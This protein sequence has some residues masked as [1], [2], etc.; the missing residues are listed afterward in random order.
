MSVKGEKK[1]LKKNKVLI[2]TKFLPVPCGQTFDSP[3]PLSR[4]F[5][6]ERYK[7]NTETVLVCLFGFSYGEI[8]VYYGN[9]IVYVSVI[10]IEKMIYFR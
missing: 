2:Q 9:T 10:P 4:F 7:G 5:G 3:L 6:A 1:F 8:M